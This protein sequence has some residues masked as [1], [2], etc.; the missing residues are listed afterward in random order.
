[1]CVWCST[2]SYTLW[3]ES[4]GMLSLYCSSWTQGICHSSV[5]RL[6]RK[7]CHHSRL[8]FSLEPELWL[9]A[10]LHNQ[11]CWIH[12]ITAICLGACIAISWWV[13][14][15]AYHTGTM[16]TGVIE[17][18]HMDT[19]TTLDLSKLLTSTQNTVLHMPWPPIT[20]VH[21]RAVAA[22]RG[23]AA[24]CIEWLMLATILKIADAMDN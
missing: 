1:M 8:G 24:L 17:R 3:S 23:A 6:Q 16:W 21:Q 22:P 13:M 11:W 7:C 5:Y 19:K 14:H 15:L 12:V 4:E 10:Q 9:E 20:A 2:F 18:R